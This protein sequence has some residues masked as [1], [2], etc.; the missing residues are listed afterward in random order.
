MDF[1]REIRGALNQ[2]A[3]HEALV[4]LVRRHKAAD[5]SQQATYDARQEIWL[6]FGLHA[7][8]HGEENRL[9]DELEYLMELVWG[10]CS[11]GNAIWGTTLSNEAHRSKG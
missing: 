11:Q 7:D 9:R 3:D 8:N 2:G 5:G 6:D 1:K 10:F 4:T